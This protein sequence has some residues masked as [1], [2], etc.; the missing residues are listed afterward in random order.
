MST[1][2]RAPDGFSS[3]KFLGHAVEMVL[4]I[5]FTTLRSEALPE[6][7]ARNPGECAGLLKKD[8]ANFI[9]LPSHQGTLSEAV[10]RYNKYSVYNGKKHIRP[11]RRSDS[12]AVKTEGEAP[13]LGVCITLFGGHL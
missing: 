5:Y 4:T 10:A 8:M 7:F 12:P 9:L 2:C 3:K 13:V 1:W 6:R 11:A